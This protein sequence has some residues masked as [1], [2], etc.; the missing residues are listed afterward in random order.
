MGLGDAQC[1]VSSSNKKATLADDYLLTM[2]HVKDK[3]K[4]QY[5]QYIV[6]QQYIQYIVDQR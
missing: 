6:D 3:N 5:I 1:Q 2:S 4:G